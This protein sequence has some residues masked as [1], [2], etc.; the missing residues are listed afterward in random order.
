[1][2]E[3]ILAIMLARVL[4]STLFPMRFI[5]C[6]LF[7]T[8]SFWTRAVTEL[9]Q[10]LRI[11]LLLTSTCNEKTELTCVYESQSRHDNPSDDDSGI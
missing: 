7:V 1:M 11:V 6:P 9:F 8:V 4:V 3:T 10:I 2:W 5:S